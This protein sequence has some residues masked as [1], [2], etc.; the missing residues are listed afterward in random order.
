MYALLKKKNYIH[1][2]LINRVTRREHS[3]VKCSQAVIKVVQWDEMPY[4]EWEPILATAGGLK[5]IEN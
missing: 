2:F 4:L 3:E 1:T 5:F